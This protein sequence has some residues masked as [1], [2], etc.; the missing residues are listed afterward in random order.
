MMGKIKKIS[1]K[2]KGKNF[3]INAKNCGSFGEIFGLMFK[4]RE[5][6]EAL[7]FEFGKP[8]NM[9]VHSFFVF[10]S[11]VAVWLDG[12]KVIAARKVKPFTFSIRPKKPFS[13]LIE[14]PINEKYHSHIKFLVGD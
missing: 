5:K 3:R 13:R 11:F 10:F 6:A 12:K 7:L 1:F 9:R 2:Y 4:G 14:I 8:V